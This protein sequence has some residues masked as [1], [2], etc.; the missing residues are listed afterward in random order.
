LILGTTF[1]WP[2]FGS[3]TIGVAIGALADWLLTR[4]S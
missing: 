3:Y 2:D 1:N 4:R